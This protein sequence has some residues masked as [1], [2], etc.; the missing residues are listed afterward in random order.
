MWSYPAGTSDDPAFVAAMGAFDR[1]DWAK[2]RALIE[3]A[4]NLAQ[5][6]ELQD[7]LAVALY[8]LRDPEVMGARERAYTLYRESGN[9]RAAAM[10]AVLY[11]YDRFIL[12][13]E[14][15][16]ANGWIARARTL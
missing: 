7:A 5:T 13:G 6:A 11:G 16:V 12:R 4:P 1:A 10:M 15:A 9:N 3:S 14:R 2:A 8:W